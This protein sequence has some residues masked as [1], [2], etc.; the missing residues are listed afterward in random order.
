MMDVKGLVKRVLHVVMTPMRLSYNKRNGVL[1]SETRRELP[2]DAYLALVSE[3]LREGHTCEI[4]VKGYSMRPFI[5]YGRDKVKLAF[6]T[7]PQIADAVLAQIVPGHYVLHRVISRDGNNLVLQGDGNVCGVEHCRVSDV[8]G[9]VIEY[10]RPNRVILAS[11][12]RLQFWVK[13]WRWV[14]PIRRFLLFLYKSLI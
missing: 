10:I 1:S 12:R 4:F 5:E 14:R 13:V 7:D 11:S 6:T 2:N 3:Y 8:C 9:V